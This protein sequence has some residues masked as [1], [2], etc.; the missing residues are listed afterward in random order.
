MAADRN[1]D[2]DK[3]E[4]ARTTINTT[5]RRIFKPL[6]SFLLRTAYKKN[7]NLEWDIIEAMGKILASIVTAA[8]LS[9]Q[10]VS[11]LN[12][13]VLDDDRNVT[14]LKTV[15]YQ[16]GMSKI[17]SKLLRGETIAPFNP[18][19]S[20]RIKRLL[21]KDENPSFQSEAKKMQTAYVKH[22][23]ENSYL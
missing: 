12:H 16:N 2:L 18:N 11:L 4:V 20:D 15:F 3:L 5:I 14:I 6:I 17:F 7:P 10:I 22:I 1:L 19:L 13:R 8:D 21:K 23:M 9:R